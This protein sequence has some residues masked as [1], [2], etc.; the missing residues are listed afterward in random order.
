MIDFSPGSSLQKSELC[1]ESLNV[2]FLQHEP[3]NNILK[4]HL[5]LLF[6]SPSK[7]GNIK[8]VGLSIASQIETISNPDVRG[9][10]QRRG[11]LENK[12]TLLLWR[13]RIIGQRS[14]FSHG[15]YTRYELKENN[16]GKYFIKIK[17]INSQ[18]LLNIMRLSNSKLY[19]I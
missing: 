17:S 6:V 9:F 12:Q 5:T 7:E 15:N 4:N 2:L 18:A 11:S 3:K 10:F 8:S 16:P 19:C 13:R 14:I 1:G